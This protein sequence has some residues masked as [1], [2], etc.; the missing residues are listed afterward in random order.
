MKK[1]FLISIH[2][3]ILV[4]II[5]MATTAACL[6]EGRSISPNPSAEEARGLGLR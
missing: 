5:G 4:A 1:S 2:Q 3:S 6:K